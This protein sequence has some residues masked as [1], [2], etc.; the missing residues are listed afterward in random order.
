MATQKIPAKPPKNM[1]IIQNHFGLHPVTT[2]DVEWSPSTYDIKVPNT[3]LIMGIE[4]E[5]EAWAWHTHFPSF[6]FETDGSLRN[7]GIEAISRPLTHKCLVGALRRFY[8]E[9]PLAVANHSDRT[10][11]HVHVNVQDFSFAQLKSLLMV[12]HT[13]ERLLFKFAGGDRESNI[14]CVPW[15]QA[16]IT[17]NVIKRLD[18]SKKKGDVIGQWLKYTA[19]NLLPILTQGTVEFRHMPGTTDVEKIISWLALIG[20][21]FETARDVPFDQIKSDI[22]KMNSVSNYRSW[23][24]TIFKEQASLIMTP[25][26]EHLLAEGVIDTKYMLVE[27]E[28]VYDAKKAEGDMNDL[29]DNLNVE[30]DRQRLRQQDALDELNRRERNRENPFRANNPIPND[31][32]QIE[33]ARV[34]PQAVY[35][36]VLGGGENVYRNNRILWNDVA[37]GNPYNVGYGVRA[38]AVTAEGVRHVRVGDTVQVN[39][40]PI[41]DEVEF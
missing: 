11:V 16:G 29:L 10:S 17:F 31:W 15:A 34:E 25:D 36:G 37:A 14:F 6:V 41:N 24:E 30:R 38:A 1:E 26:T 5:V 18:D 20:R 7:G 21:L 9:Y 13:I 2:D 4:L 35:T 22:I 8:K 19:V 32:G 40:E 23:L 3:E 12:Y 27:K 28:R 33:A 39:P